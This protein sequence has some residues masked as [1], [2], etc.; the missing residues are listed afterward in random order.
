MSN[1]RQETI[2][3]IAA[4]MREALEAVVKVGYPHNK[5]QQITTVK[6]HNAQPMA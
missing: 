6:L 2:A 5:K 4:K 1:A 3:D